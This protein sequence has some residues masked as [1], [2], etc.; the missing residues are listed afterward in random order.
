MASSIAGM[1]PLA[2]FHGCTC[3][4]SSPITFIFDSLHSTEQTAGS[5]L[6]S[7]S[8]GRRAVVASL[9]I[10]FLSVI[11]IILPSP[12]PLHLQCL[13]RFNFILSWSNTFSRV[14][15]CG[16]S[17]DGVCCLGEGQEGQTWSNSKISRQDHALH[18]H[19][20]SYVV[21]NF[22]H[23]FNIKFLIFFVSFIILA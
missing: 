8:R 4:S 5:I 10:L 13:V 3:Y 12:T 14:L 22:H 16:P 21:L 18:I 15:Q 19:L 6:L 1:S 9:L 2:L 17:A 7:F 20:V 11:W 23:K